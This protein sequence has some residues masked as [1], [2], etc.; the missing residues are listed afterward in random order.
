MTVQT[1]HFIEL[2]DLLALRFT[3]K[4]C[5]STLSLPLSDTK[6]IKPQNKRFLDE[7]PS[8]QCAWA[9]LNGTTFEPVITKAASALNQLREAMH[10]DPPVPMGFS[11]LLEITSEVKPCNHEV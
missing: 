3:C 8:C 6:L 4:E 2:T 11:L 7:C 1:K 9:S 10:G 5:G